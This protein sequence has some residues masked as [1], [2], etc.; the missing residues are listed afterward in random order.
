MNIQ[1]TDSKTRRFTIFKRLLN[2]EHLSYQQLSEEYFVSRSSIAND[3]SYI[4]KQFAK[5]ELLLTFDN[6]G[7]FFNGN[8]IK[9]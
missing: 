6:S 1:Y 4:K 9:V 8:E 3:I 7:T 5:E 2:Y